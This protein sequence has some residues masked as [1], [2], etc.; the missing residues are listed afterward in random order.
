ML[1][2]RRF[3]CMS[4]KDKLIQKH[5][6]IQYMIPCKGKVRILLVIMVIYYWRI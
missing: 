4:K 5:R 3:K 2:D 6:I 1:F